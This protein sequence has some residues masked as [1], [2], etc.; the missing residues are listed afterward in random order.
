M[1]HQNK[2]QTNDE[3]V[4]N[5]AL[6]QPVL[7]AEV[8]ECLSPQTGE[9]YLDVT[10]GYAGHARAVADMTNAIERI[11]LVDRDE[12]A[13]AELQKALPK[14]K[15]IHRDF[16]SASQQ[17]LEQ[18]SKY[19]MILADLGVSSVHLDN[20]SRGF[21][22]MTE[23]ELDMRM[24]NRQTLTAAEIVNTYDEA[25]ISRLLW[26]YGEEPKSRQI[27]RLIVQARPITTTTQLA[28][29]V[30][31]AWPGHS[32]SHPATRTFQAL[33]IAVNDEI[34]MLEQA[35]PIWIDLLEDGG[36]LAIISFHSLEDRVVK[37]HFNHYSEGYEA[38]VAVITK[39]PVTAS[40]HELALNPRSRS[41]KLRVVV[42]QTNGLRQK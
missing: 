35:I 3:T 39:K 27:A 37:Q 20:A 26:K 10:A 38:K 34:H 14:A 21:S 13:I 40:E 6:H 8:L 25:E 24:D 31:R 32:K 19:N 12:I 28:A 23:A 7:L 16:L 30:K 18:G 2:K 5:A 36:R 17:L 29:V 1:N 9:S 11:T 4:A 41:A 15:T 42:K 22:F 33:R